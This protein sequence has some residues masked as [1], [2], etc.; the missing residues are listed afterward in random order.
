[1]M[2]FQYLTCFVLLVCA[3][4]GKE[5]DWVP[6]K[7]TDSKEIVHVTLALKQ[8]NVEWLDETL[9]AVSSPDS[10]KYGSYM[11]LENIVQHVHA[12]ERGVS[13]VRNYF[14]AFNITPQFTMGNGF[15]VLDIPAS[16][17]E[18]MFSARFYN[19][20]HRY[21]STLT[22][23]RTSMYTLPKAIASYVDFTCCIDQ[24]PRPN[25]VGA[26]RSYNTKGVS[27]S[28]SEIRSSY[29][30][31]DYVATNVSTTQAIA[32]FL[33]QYFSPSDLE[34]FQKKFDIPSDPIAKVI[35][36]NTHLLAG[37][38]ASLDVEYITGMH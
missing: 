33:K 6:I 26:I 25:T 4:F 38:E 1:M 27:A 23:I 21:D 2:S 22:T 36:K 30:I 12:D 32:G 24:L 20:Q 31:N 17:A 8:V 16:A 9:A 19:Y 11:T 14:T 15:A 13:A 5:E 37:V 29:E 3:V 10:P 18:E 34:R 35:G 7:R 28:P